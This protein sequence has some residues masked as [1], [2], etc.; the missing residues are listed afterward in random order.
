[1]DNLAKNDDKVDIHGG[2]KI[3]VIFFCFYDR[4]HGFNYYDADDDAGD[5]I[6]LIHGDRTNACSNHYG[7]FFTATPSQIAIS[8]L[9][10]RM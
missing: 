7:K 10:V 8:A 1:M 5:T 9:L 2:D 3:M 6:T 4:N